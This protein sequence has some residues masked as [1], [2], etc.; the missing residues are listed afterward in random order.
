MTSA[1]P[2]RW[3][4]LAY[5]L[6]GM[7]LAMAALPVYLQVPAYY[8]THLGLAIGST[9]WILFLTRLVD[10]VQDPWL[11]RV[12]DGLSGVRLQ[13]WMIAA[14]LLLALSFCGLWL[15]P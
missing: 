10:T 8:T 7:P 1:T 4:Y 2:Q 9:G 13:L 14:A 12:I 6:L 11:G 5:G 15:P 3:R